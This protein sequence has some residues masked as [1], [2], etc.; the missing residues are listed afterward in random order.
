MI[1]KVSITVPVCMLSFSV[2]K[3]LL[4]SYVNWFIDF[5]GLRLKVMMDPSCLKH[6]N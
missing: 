2:D 6:L 3:I 1:D 5:R 4:P